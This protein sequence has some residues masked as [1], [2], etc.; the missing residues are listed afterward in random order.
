M[1]GERF[2][3]AAGAME[4]G[5]CG[6]AGFFDDEAAELVGLGKEDWVLYLVTIG[7]T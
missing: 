4:L 1:I 7:Q 5:A 6:I 3:L 2:Q